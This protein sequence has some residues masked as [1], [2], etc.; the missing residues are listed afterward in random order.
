[1]AATKIGSKRKSAPRRRAAARR[2]RRRVLRANVPE[3]ASCSE[4]VKIVDGESNQMYGPSTL[5]LD[6][7]KRA[8]TIAA[9]YQEFRITKVK[10]TFKP[11]FDTFSATTDATTAYRVP[12]MYYMIDKPQALPL[13]TSIATLRAMGAKPHRFDDKNVVVQYSPGV[14][15]SMYDGAAVSIA[16]SA[17]ISPW[18]NTNAAPDAVW[19][20]ST[21]DHA[22]LFYYLD[23][24]ALPG[25]GT[26]EYGVDLEVQFEF[27]KPLLPV[28][29]SEQPTTTARSFVIAA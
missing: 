24:G 7:F 22:G 8:S 25:D 6:M 20:P 19:T 28:V 4:L 26:Y 21:I 3:R 18:L 15:S 23:A 16:A 13:T 11:Q 29:A 17:K 14:Q 12:Q 27:R 1:M 2:P 9:G 5:S 10:W